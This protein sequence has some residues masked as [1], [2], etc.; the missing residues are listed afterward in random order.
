ML[1]RA[2][3]GRGWPDYELDGLVTHTVAAEQFVLPAWHNVTTSEIMDHSPL[4][5]DRAGRSTTTHPVKEIAAEI[6]DVVQD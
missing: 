4:L 6:V 2:F 5:A 1:F 3:F